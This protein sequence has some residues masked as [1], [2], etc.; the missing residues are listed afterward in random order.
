M[1]AQTNTNTTTTTTES[2]PRGA[3]RHVA[4]VL[5]LCALAMPAIANAQP[6]DSDP[7][8]TGYSSV[9]SITGGSNG[10]GPAE[11]ATAGATVAD[12][13][14]APTGKSAEGVDSRYS[15]LNAISGS[16][17]DAPTFASSSPTGADE[18]FDWPSALV[19][20]GAA[21]ALAALGVAAL[22][23]VRRRSTV[24]PSPSTS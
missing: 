22:L 21:L 14:T 1:R 16:P 18:G 2:R 7:I 17:A 24:T 10:S 3:A 15:S 11:T 12:A 9:N 4:L 5:S 8:D 6:I 20:A 23:T 13:S 19:G